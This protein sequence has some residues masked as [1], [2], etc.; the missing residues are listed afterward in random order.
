MK[1]LSLF[2]LLIAIAFMACKKQFADA[3]YAPSTTAN[4]WFKADPFYQPNASIYIDSTAKWRTFKA[5]PLI[6]DNDPNKYGF[7]NLFVAGKGVNALNM[8]TIYTSVPNGGVSADSGLYNITIPKCFEFLPSK[9]DPTKG[10]V[11]VIPQKVKIVRKDFSVYYIGI[12]GNGEFD[13]NA[14]T[15][16]VD[17]TFDDS[18]IGGSKAI[19]RK[20][21]FQP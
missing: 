8:T 10:I 15:F 2:F 19:L 9:D 21:M 7:G 16:T 6:Y 4:V 14:K 1:K 5:F 18:D 17:I 13:T 12:S 11:N 20:Y 3:T